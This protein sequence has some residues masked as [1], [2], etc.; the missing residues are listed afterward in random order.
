MSDTR[1]PDTEGCKHGL[2]YCTQCRRDRY[3][4]DLESELSTQSACIAAL[5]RKAA[6]FDALR[7]ALDALLVEVE[8]LDDYSLTRDIE[9]HKAQ[10]CWDYVIDQAR[11]ALLEATEAA[12]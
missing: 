1:T 3:I 4:A 2:L 7:S 12:K 8:S 10:A 9:P 11:T 5:E 6:H